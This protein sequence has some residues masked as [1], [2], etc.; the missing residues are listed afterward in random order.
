MFSVEEFVSDP[1]GKVSTIV[2]A[3][4]SQLLDVAAK[5]H[6]E[7]RKTDTKD[8]LKNGILQHCVDENFVSYESAK[9]L[10]DISKDVE[11][12][13]LA[14]QLEKRKI[15]AEERKLAARKGKETVRARD[16]S[17]EIGNG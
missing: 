8:D 10:M 14:L 16:S 17:K 6:V 4:K 2:Y 15:E 7:V 1:Q 9:D 13:R 3:T 11:Y 5:F 12:M